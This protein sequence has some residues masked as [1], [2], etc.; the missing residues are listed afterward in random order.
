MTKTQN[1]LLTLIMYFVAVRLLIGGVEQL[2]EVKARL[3][4]LRAMEVSCVL[5]TGE[6]M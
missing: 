6:V 2:Y 4:E 5:P 1:A 3:A